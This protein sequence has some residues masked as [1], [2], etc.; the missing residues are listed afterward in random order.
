MTTVPNPPQYNN[1]PVILVHLIVKAK[2]LPED[3][4]LPGIYRKYPDR[5]WCAA[6]EVVEQSESYYPHIPRAQCPACAKAH[7]K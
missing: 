2:E 7:T 5:Y 6:Y 4:I 3:E 1:E